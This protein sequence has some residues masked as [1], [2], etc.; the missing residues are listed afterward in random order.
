MPCPFRTWHIKHVV[1]RIKIHLLILF[2]RCDSNVRSKMFGGWSIAMIGHN[3]FFFTLYDFQIVFRIILLWECQWARRGREGHALE[4]RTL[5]KQP[6]LVWTL[7]IPLSVLITIP[8]KKEE[9]AENKVQ[10]SDDLNCL[11]KIMR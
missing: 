10:F 9:K 8:L 4:K 1:T 5:Q 2:L 6:E 3:A 7:L 11:Q